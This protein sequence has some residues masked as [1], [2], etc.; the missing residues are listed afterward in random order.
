MRAPSVSISKRAFGDHFANLGFD[1]VVALDLGFAR[2][3]QVRGGHRR[4]AGLPRDV[5]GFARQIGQ[6][7][8]TR[9]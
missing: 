6:I 2:R 1:E 3:A 8:E 4:F 9:R 7:G 5:T